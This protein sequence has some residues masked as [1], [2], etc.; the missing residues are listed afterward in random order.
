MSP[1]PL[2]LVFLLASCRQ[3]GDEDLGLQVHAGG[4][5]I[6][7]KGLA[8]TGVL[9]R[10]LA[11]PAAAVDAKLG[12][13]QRRQELDLTL[14]GGGGEERF[15]ETWRTDVDGRGAVQALHSTSHDDLREWVFAEG[16]LYTRVAT[17][18]FAMRSPEGD[19]VERA[20]GEQEGV[21]AGM[22]AVLGR[23][24]AREEGGVVTAPGGRRAARLV[25]HLAGRA[26]GFDDDDP[27]H[28]W[29]RSLKVA[30]LE[31]EILIDAASGAPLGARLDAEYRFD[32]QG[33]EIK[34]AVVYRGEIGDIGTPRQIRPPADAVAR[35]ARPR[36]LV[37]RDDLLGGIAAKR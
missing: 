12:P 30:R 2:L 34:V 23:F 33:R 35:L 4:E 20:R 7:L 3:G 37:D 14:T 31:G 6:D 5:T 19:E 29:R 11:A 36:P 16:K 32:R 9:E 15:H 25:L 28:A 22:L 21:L 24:A 18:R 17:P 8:R 10:V 13:H 1:R 26:A 27:A